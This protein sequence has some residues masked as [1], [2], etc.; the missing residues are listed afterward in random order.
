MLLV[1]DAM[2]GVAGFVVLLAAPWA[3]H[4]INKTLEEN[5]KL[6]KT[7]HV[8]GA[9]VI[10][11]PVVSLSMSQVQQRTA[12]L[13]PQVTQQIGIAAG[14]AWAAICLITPAV[15]LACG[16]WDKANKEVFRLTVGFCLCVNAA[17]GGWAVLNEGARLVKHAEAVEVVGPVRWAGPVGLL[18]LV[19]LDYLLLRLA[20]RVYPP[21]DAQTHQPIPAAPPIL[22]AQPPVYEPPAK[23][24]K[25]RRKRGSSGSNPAQPT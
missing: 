15:I 1:L 6:R 20:G 25:T 14:M 18:G 12:T 19:V 21:D 17:F 13:S 22:T 5:P 2:L 3:Y 10:L 9:L 7:L 8:F 24:P 16:A 11:V 4:W 23:A